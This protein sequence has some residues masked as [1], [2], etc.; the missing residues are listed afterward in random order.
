M[1]LNIEL[2]KLFSFK[3]IRNHYVRKTGEFCGE[4]IRRRRVAA[5]SSNRK[6]K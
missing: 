2:E 3:F 4:E 6:N 5:F 1:H